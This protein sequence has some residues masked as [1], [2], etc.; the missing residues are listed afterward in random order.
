MPEP[1]LPASLSTAGPT[2]HR[3]SGEH[4]NRR[5]PSLLYFQHHLHNKCWWERSGWSSTMG[6][7]YIKNLKFI[8]EL[9]WYSSTLDPWAACHPHP[10]R[11][12]AK[13]PEG[14]F[15]WFTDIV[16]KAMCKRYTKKQEAW[17]VHRDTLD[18]CRIIGYWWWFTVSVGNS[19]NTVLQTYICGMIKLENIVIGN[20]ESQLV[21]GWRSSS[22]RGYTINQ[23]FTTCMTITWDSGYASDSNS[24]HR[25]WGTRLCIS[26]K[27]P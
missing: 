9:E 12:I 7:H 26:N 6:Q 20:A 14:I 15:L 4:H 17:D 16:E 10:H 24:T 18:S 23:L 22:Y 3:S 13:K 27:L 8:V 19:L 2:H 5:S 1:G 25:R 11:I 21:T